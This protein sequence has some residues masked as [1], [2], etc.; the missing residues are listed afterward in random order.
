MAFIL[1]IKIL[2]C[3]FFCCFF[4]CKSTTCSSFSMLDKACPH[5]GE[6]NIF[7]C[8]WIFHG[9]LPWFMFQSAKMLTLFFPVFLGTFC[10]ITK[11]LTVLV[12][13]LP[14]GWVFVYIIKS[15]HSLFSKPKRISFLFIKKSDTLRNVFAVK[16]LIPLTRASL[17]RSSPNF[18]P[19][20]I[21]QLAFSSQGPR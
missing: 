13:V 8:D 14:T 12:C 5:D 19:I 11:Y 7:L 17:C 2:V 1:L 18:F 16:F 10:H 3:F 4:F 15:P 6:I 9:E 20:V 21:T